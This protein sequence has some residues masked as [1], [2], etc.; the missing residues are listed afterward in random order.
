MTQVTEQRQACTATAKLASASDVYTIC[1]SR[2]V[3]ALI[4]VTC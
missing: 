3:E 1:L 4:N 2:L